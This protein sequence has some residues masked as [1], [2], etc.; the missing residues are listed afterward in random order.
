[1]RPR[2]NRL[3]RATSKT[4]SSRCVHSFNEAEAQSPRKAEMRSKSLT[5]RGL[6][7]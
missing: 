3:G 6:L 4:A 7:Q 5:L 2:R 1:M